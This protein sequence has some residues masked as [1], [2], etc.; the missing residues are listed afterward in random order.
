MEID[1]WDEVRTAFQVARLRTV[2]GAADVLGVVGGGRWDPGEAEASRKGTRRLGDHSTP[3]TGG[4]T[5]A[6]SL[7]TSHPSCS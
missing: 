1:N 7:A 5:F 4:S 6:T 3:S 2:S